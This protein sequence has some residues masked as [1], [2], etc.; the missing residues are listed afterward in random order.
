MLL[1]AVGGFISRMYRVLKRRP[2]LG[3]ADDPGRGGHGS[4]SGS[5][6]TMDLR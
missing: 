4:R 1:G 3:G 6:I 5:A 2:S